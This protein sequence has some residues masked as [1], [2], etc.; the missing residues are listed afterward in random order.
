VDPIDK[1]V[2]E[3]RSLRV[4]GA[5]NVARR[6]IDALKGLIQSREWNKE[7]LFD[8][9]RTAVVR[10]ARSRPTEPAMRDALTYVLRAMAELKNSDNFANEIVRRLGRRRFPMAER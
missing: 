6:A 1:A 9:L 5:R 7:D 2:E 8:A 10:L 4:Q 3:I